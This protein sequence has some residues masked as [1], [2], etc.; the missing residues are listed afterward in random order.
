MTRVETG[1]AEKMYEGI[2]L[3]GGVCFL[4]LLLRGVFCIHTGLLCKTHLRVKCK[5]VGALLNWRTFG[6]QLVGLHRKED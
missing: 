6:G 2:L 3:G 5:D 1:I 4:Q